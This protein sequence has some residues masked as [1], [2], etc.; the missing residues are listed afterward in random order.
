MA[1]ERLPPAPFSARGTGCPT[2]LKR[3]AALGFKS[4]SAAWPNGR[5]RQP[6][7]ATPS[8]AAAYRY[9]AENADMG[10]DFGQRPV[11]M[12]SHVHIAESGEPRAESQQGRARRCRSFDHPRRSVP[13]S[14]PSLESNACIARRH[15]WINSDQNGP[16][17]KSLLAQRRPPLLTGTVACN[18]MQTDATIL[19]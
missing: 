2:V 15:P 10:I 4:A 3:H 5:L 6:I 7:S 9:F 11:Q 14:V 18:E 13:I 19:K 16:L 8:A 12:W 1:K 17:Q